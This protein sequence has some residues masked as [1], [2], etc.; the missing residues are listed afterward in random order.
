MSSVLFDELVENLA[1]LPGIGRKTAVRL[2][3]ALVD[4]RELAGQLAKALSETA[5]KVSECS[6]CRNLT[7]NDICEICSNSSRSDS[8][9]IVHNAADLRAIEDA[10]LF[11]GK[12]FVLHGFLA[13][14]DGIGSEELGIEKLKKMTKE[15]SPAELILALDSTTDGEATSAYLTKVLEQTGCRITRL[16]RGLPPGASVEFADSL[17]LLQAFEGRQKV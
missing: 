16:A 11:R 5:E 3:F 12:Y 4:N 9:C 14:L 1:R 8:I 13:P 17:T 10:G 15:V 7:E 6:I 2:S